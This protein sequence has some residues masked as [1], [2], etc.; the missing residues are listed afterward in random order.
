MPSI[1]LDDVL[2]K[3][4][5][6]RASDVF[7]KE[8][9]PPIY[10]LHGKITRSDYPVQ[11]GDDIR[12]L[13]YG[14]MTPQQIQRYEQRREM[15]LGFSRPFSRF[16]CNVY[17][18][19]GSV[20]MCLRLIPLTMPHLD[21]LGVPPVL[22]EL[23]KQKQGL[24]LVTG[25]TGSGKST[26]LAA[27][28]NQINENQPK[29]IVTIEDPIEFVHQD[30]MG[31]VNQREVNID[32]ESFQAGMKYVLRQAPDVILIGEMRDVETFSICLQAAETGHL[33]F[34]T[35]HTPSAYETMDRIIN[36]FPPHEKAQI[37]MRMSNSLRGV[38]SQK[39]VPRGDGSG[40]VP[41]VEVMINT[42]TVAK[43][44]EEGR[45]G[46]IYEHIRDGEYWGMQTMNQCLLRYWRAGLISEEDALVYAGNS[47]ELR[48][49]MRRPT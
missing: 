3:A 14:L 13:A 23:P 30:K 19:K 32:T 22:K 45:F 37:C 29:N 33:V 10:R 7:F 25:P 12:Q 49:M 20:G 31:I 6:L 47:T 43:L 28:L 15:D 40:R 41:G 24:V 9:A 21:E 36:M 1:S 11:S 18:Q 26:T 44:V 38:V 34:S 46:M 4:H 35:V 48:Q 2:L 27:M 42:P 39:L 5:E 16:R 8:N 17:Q